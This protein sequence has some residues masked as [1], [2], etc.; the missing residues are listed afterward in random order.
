MSY[1]PSDQGS[2]K[3]KRVFLSGRPSRATPLKRRF[4]R[5]LRRKPTKAEAHFWKEIGLNGLGMPMVRQAVLSGYIVDFFVPRIRL[6]IEI[7]G[8]YHTV[9]SV[10]KYDQKRQRILERRGNWFLRFTNEEALSMDRKDIQA[11]VYAAWG[12]RLTSNV[13]VV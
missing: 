11:A 5:R 1:R 4:A 13:P 8:G 3:Q 10:Q 7:D 12:N 9:E 6:V 2:R